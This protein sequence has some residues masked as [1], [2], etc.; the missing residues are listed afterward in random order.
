[1]AINLKTHPYFKISADA[2]TVQDVRVHYKILE[3]IAFV[4][5]GVRVSSLARVKEHKEDTILAWLRSAAQ[6][7]EG[8]EEALLVDYQ[9]NRGQLD[10]LW[11]Y[12]GN[13]GEKKAIPKPTEG[14]SSGGPP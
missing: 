12:V 4:A 9:L 11:S 13:K 2:S 14:T 10:A 6:H 8:V 5:E 7:A 1:M 3:T